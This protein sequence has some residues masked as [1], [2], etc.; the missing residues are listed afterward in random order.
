MTGAVAPD[1]FLIAL[2]ALDLLAD[3]AASV[4]LLLLVDDA[5]W[6]DGPSRACWRSSPGGWSRS[7]S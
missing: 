3:S 1:P 4:P 2:A 7:Q 5:H 6:L